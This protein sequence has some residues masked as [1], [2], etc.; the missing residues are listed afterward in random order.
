M[1]VLDKEIEIIKQDLALRPDFNLLD[2]FRLFDIKEKG[3]YLN[4]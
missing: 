1:I 2:C 3:K 4:A